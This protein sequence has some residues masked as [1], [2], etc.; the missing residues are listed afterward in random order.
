MSSLKRGDY[1]FRTVSGLSINADSESRADH[2]K[3]M[4]IYTLLLQERQRLTYLQWKK[5]TLHI[6]VLL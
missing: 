5:A 2:I 4:L 6:S 1:L 3:V